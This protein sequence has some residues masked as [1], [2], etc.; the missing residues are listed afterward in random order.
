MSDTYCV[1]GLYEPDGI[2]L[3]YIGIT[4]LNEPHNLI[5]RLG[6]HL[7]ESTKFRGDR[8]VYSRHKSE[9]IRTLASNNN[10]V[11]IIKPIITGLS[12]EKARTYES[13]LIN[14]YSLIG[15]DLLNIDFNKN[16]R[17]YS[18]ACGEQKP[19]AKLCEMDIYRIADLYNSGYEIPQ[20]VKLFNVSSSSI[21]NV[22]IRKTWKH[23]DI[24]V[25]Y[26]K[27]YKNYS[28]KRKPVLK[29][30]PITNSI[31]DKYDCIES[32]AKKNNCHYDTIQKCVRGKANSAV[33]YIWR[34][35]V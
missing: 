29:I 12:E 23:I 15:C 35:A 1:Y 11:P 18:S 3:R 9:W 14:Q 2:T 10:Q 26:R 22:L 31:I 30:N 28:P 17:R 20:L 4:N 6:Y 25:T 32:A 27:R 5:K 8:G 34:Y 16:K 24:N 13:N 21:H 33:G 19:D 7:V